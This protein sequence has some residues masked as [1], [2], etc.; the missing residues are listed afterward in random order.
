MKRRMLVVF[1]VLMMSLG[2]ALFSGR[3]MDGSVTTMDDGD[4]PIRVVNQSPDEVCYVFISVS[5][6]DVWGEDWLS[7]DEVVAPGGSK[8]FNVPAGQ[9][10]I[11]LEACDQAVMATGWFIDNNTTITV[12]ASR[13]TSRLFVDNTSDTEV[14]YVFIAP[15]TGDEWGDDWLG[16]NETIMTGRTRIFYVRPGMYDMMVRDCGDEPLAEEYQVDLSSDMTWTLHND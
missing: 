6:S 3:R 11:L 5:D 9:H 15:S 10:D 4:F 16:A 13:A 7:G 14:C 2:C 12:G 1:M 8:T